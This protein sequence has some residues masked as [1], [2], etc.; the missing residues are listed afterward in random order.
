MEKYEKYHL[1]TLLIVLLQWIGTWKKN[2]LRVNIF[3]TN[4][5]LVHDQSV[6]KPMIDCETLAGFQQ[7]LRHVI[8]FPECPVLAAIT[9]GNIDLSGGRWQGTHAIYVCDQD[10][11]LVGTP[12]RLCQSSGQWNGV[13]PTCIYGMNETV[14]TL[15]LSTLSFWNRLFHLWIWTHSLLPKK[16]KW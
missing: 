7:Y 10:F 14:F 4:R 6:L 2:K 9:N 13:E 3:P 5:L 16:L 11:A 8:L 1:D 15:N 12:N